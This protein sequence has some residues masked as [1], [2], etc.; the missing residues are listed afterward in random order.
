MAI[1]KSSN[2]FIEEVAIKMLH[3]VMYVQNFKKDICIF[4]PLFF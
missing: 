1:W 2:I 3:I 4:C